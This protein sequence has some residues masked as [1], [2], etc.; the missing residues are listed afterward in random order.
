LAGYQP[1]NSLAGLHGDLI[2]FIEWRL[3]TG[4]GKLFSNEQARASM[5]LSWIEPIRGYLA[6][7]RMSYRW[8]VLFFF[9]FLGVIG[10][11]AS[12]WMAPK[13]GI[14]SRSIGLFFFLFPLLMLLK[15]THTVLFKR[16]RISL[17]ESQIVIDRQGKKTIY[18]YPTIKQIGYE[19]AGKLQ[20]SVISIFPM[21][22]SRAL[23]FLCRPEV[24]ISAIKEIVPTSVAVRTDLK[25]EDYG[26]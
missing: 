13:Y 1:K 9:S 4:Y 5:T 25:N 26:L 23:S 11:C 14:W 17:E 19:D 20:A 21:D 6:T 7:A 8:N 10:F 12:F 24:T 15:T 18:P 22:G 2:L 16:A 3:S